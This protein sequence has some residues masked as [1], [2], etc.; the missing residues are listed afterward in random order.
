MARGSEIQGKQHPV[1]KTLP[2]VTQSEMKHHPFTMGEEVINQVGNVTKRQVLH[3]LSVLHV[4]TK[5]GSLTA[6]NLVV[7]NY[8]L[9]ESSYASSILLHTIDW[10]YN[11]FLSDHKK[12]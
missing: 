7:I 11:L 8:S 10:I 2:L 9:H 3:I 5:C 12:A 6:L 4:Q 1:S